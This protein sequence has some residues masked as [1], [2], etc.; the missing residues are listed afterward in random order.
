MLIVLSL[1]VVRAPVTTTALQVASR[2]LLVWG[3]CEQFPSVPA[4][5]LFYSSMLIAWSLTEVVR[6]GYF[7][8]A[9]NGY[10]P[11]ILSWLRYNLF[12]ILYPLGIS[13]EMALVYK[14]ILYAKKRDERLE[15]VLYGILGIYFPGKFCLFSHV[16][17]IIGSRIFQE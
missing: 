15:W 14:S 1:G 3:I 16:F 11:S 2:V 4:N 13:S 8:F 10:I 12:F 6:Y 17:L 9:L 5:S 7:V